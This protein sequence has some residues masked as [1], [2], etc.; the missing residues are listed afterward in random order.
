MFDEFALQ[1][2]KSYGMLNPRTLL[3]D[4]VGHSAAMDTAGTYGHEVDGKSVRAS[5]SLEGIF[6]RILR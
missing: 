2:E 5:E 1:R 3:K 4:V 6:D